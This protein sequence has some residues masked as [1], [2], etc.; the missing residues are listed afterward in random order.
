MTKKKL[1]RKGFISVSEESQGR[2]LRQEPR[3]RNGCR[4]HGGAL[5]TG[6]LLL[7]A[8]FF[9]YVPQ[10]YLLIG[11]CV[12]SHCDASSHINRQSRKNLQTFLQASLM[13][14]GIFLIQFSSKMTLPSVKLT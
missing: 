6:L 3:D 7:G 11:D 2:N 13:Q 9:S 8:S 10:G 1:E 14:G 12:S 5:L 4:G